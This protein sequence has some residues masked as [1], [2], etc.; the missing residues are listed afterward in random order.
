MI[1]KIKHHFRTR[2]MNYTMVVTPTRIDLICGNNSFFAEYPF[3]TKETGFLTDVHPQYYYLMMNILLMRLDE[4]LI[5]EITEKPLPGKPI[6]SYSG[7]ADSSALL[8]VT[9]GLPVHIYRSYAQVYGTRQ[10]R[11]VTEVGAM[12]IK[13]DFERIREMY[14]LRH[15]F[16]I[17]IG[18]AAMYMP[19]LPLLKTNTIALG[20]IFDDVAFNYSVPFSFNVNFEKSQMM[21]LITNLREF[22]IFII[23]PLAGYSE[24]LTTRIAASS[25]IKSVTSCH[26][27]GN[28]QTCRMCYK[29]FR[30]QAILGAPLKWKEVKPVILPYLLKRPLKMASSTIYAIQKSGYKDPYFSRFMD[31]DVSWLERVNPDF[32]KNLSGELLPGYQLQTFPDSLSIDDFVTR[33]NDPELYKLDLKYGTK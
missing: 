13:T 17:G 12:V 27:L 10:M 20:V 14:G 26:T 4:I 30:K 25:G 11:T 15:G 18:Y 16:S 5:P 29:C 1:T 3:L 19:L 23:C 22:G 2:K 8:H 24:V 7:G 31:I 32:M 33:V 28:E 9:K 6:V 21:K